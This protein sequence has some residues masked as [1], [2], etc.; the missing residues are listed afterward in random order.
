MRLHKCLTPSTGK[1]WSWTTI[2]ATGLGRLWKN[3]VGSIIHGSPIYSSSDRA[4]P[5]LNTGIREAR[6]EILAFMDDDVIVEP[7]WLRNLSKSERFLRA[8]NYYGLV[9]VEYRPARLSLQT[10]RRKRPKVGKPEN[11][12]IGDCGNSPATGADLETATET[13]LQGVSV[14]EGGG[15]RGILS[16]RTRKGP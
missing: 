3:F 10:A 14:E 1:F 6:G 13:F 12:N 16:P 8:I 5:A 9:E 7:T 2:Q 11:R 4:S 15:N